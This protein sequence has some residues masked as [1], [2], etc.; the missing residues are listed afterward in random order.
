MMVSPKRLRPLLLLVASLC[1]VACADPPADR[2]DA[3]VEAASKAEDLED[4]LLFFTSASAEML[5][6]THKVATSRNKD[7]A[8]L[9][10][11][12]KLLPE[13]EV[14]EVEERGNLAL[15]KLQGS[16]SPPIRMIREKGEWVIDAY[17]LPSFWKPLRAEAE[18]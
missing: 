1:I 16:E 4:Y 15:V 18:E 8:Y 13:A 11:I 2:Y 6:G 3:A 17:S 7:L 9:S 14:E 5:R 10:D 12:R